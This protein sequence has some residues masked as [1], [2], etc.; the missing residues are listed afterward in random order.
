VECVFELFDTEEGR[1][2]GGWIGGCGSREGP[3]GAVEGESEFR[4]AGG[5]GG[6]GVDGEGVCTSQGGYIDHLAYYLICV[7]YFGFLRGIISFL[8]LHV[9]E[10]WGVAF[11]NFLTDIP[12]K[13]VL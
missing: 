3:R 9:L 10:F 5:D 8:W 6:G 7:N 11:L 12:G 4:T 1:G 13:V 2:R